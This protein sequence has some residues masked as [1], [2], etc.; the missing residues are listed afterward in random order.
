M[1]VKHSWLLW[2]KKNLGGETLAVVCIS[3]A[4]GCGA[5]LALAFK[6]CAFSSRHSKQVQ[7]GLERKRI[8]SVADEGLKTPESYK[9]SEEHC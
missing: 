4:Q 8:F 7:G 3:R 6:M 2:L 1:D 5:G 9:I